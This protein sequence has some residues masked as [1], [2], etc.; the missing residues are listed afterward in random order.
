MNVPN[1][2]LSRWALKLQ[3]TT[4]PFFTALVPII[5]TLKYISLSILDYLA[6]KEDRIFELI[7]RPDLWN[8]DKDPIQMRLQYLT[9]DSQIKDALLY[10][11]LRFIWL[12][13]TSPLLG[14]IHNGGQYLG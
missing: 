3:H 12:P 4:L 5:K 2:R 11:L 14:R 9:T 1:D 13:M 8:L 10:K 7:V 6:P